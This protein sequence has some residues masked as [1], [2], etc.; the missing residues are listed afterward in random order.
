MPY[1]GSWK[2]DDLLTFSCNTHNPKTMNAANAA[3]DPAYRIY[4]DETEAPILSGTMAR[5]DSVNTTG[6]YTEQVQ[7]TAANGF[8]KGKTY[9]IYISAT[10]DKYLGTMHHTFQVEA[11]VSV[12]SISAGGVSDI[13]GAVDDALVAQKLDHLVAVADS[14]DVTDDSII[15]KLASKTADW[16]EFDNETDSLEAIRDRGDEAWAGGGTPLADILNIQALIPNSID[17]AGTATVRIALGLTNMLAD[18]PTEA[19]IT[20]GTITIDRKAI[21]GTSWTNIVN[22]AACLEADGLIYYDEVFDTGSGY[23]AGDSIRMIFKNQKITVDGND[24]EIT[25]NDG[26]TFQTYI[27]EAMRGTDGANTT[28]PDAAGTAASLLSSLESHG[29]SEWKTATGFSTFDAALDEVVSNVKKVNDVAVSDID[30]FKADVSG[31]STFDAGTDEVAANVKKVNDVTVSSIDEFKADVSGLST[32]DAS[33]EEVISNV[34]KVNDGLVTSVDDF[35][36]DV[37]GLSTFDNATDEVV[38]NVK[39]V[40]DVSVS[41]IDDFKADVSNLATSNALATHDAKLD[42]VKA[43]TDLLPADIATETT[44]NAVKAQTDKMKFVGDDIKATLDGEAVVLP[45]DLTA[46]MKAS[47]RTQVDNG[48][49]SYDAPTR[50]EATSDKDE[51]IV[52]INANEVKID[53]IQASIDALENLSV[54]EIFNKV[55]DGTITFQKAMEV[56]LAVA[57]AK[58]AVESGKVVIF[59]GQDG[60]AKLTMTYNAS[61]TEMT[62][63]VA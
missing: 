53:S 49:V 8:E 10:V 35:K 60:N 24:Y 29:D 52:Q 55:V 30:D 7:L 63:E 4:E 40:N 46:T 13:E 45:D 28:I 17:I 50:A 5:I 56:I 16:S 11:E 32:F 18:L 43:K 23:A 51:I 2:I 31:L 61:E 58:G 42:A 15:A 14:D 19:E 3:G 27:R 59:K 39:K 37:S 54:D 12:N 48:L 62:S 22:A 9:H 21:G 20:P 1:I 25:G 41:N 26:W 36:A 44:V 34:K 47:V 57:G 33:S 6:F 38:S